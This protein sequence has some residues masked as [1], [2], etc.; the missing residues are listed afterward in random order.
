MLPA[1]FEPAGLRAT[2]RDLL[3]AAPARHSLPQPFYTAAAIH[4][5]DLALIHHRHW[6]FAGLESEVAQP[7]DIQAVEIGASSVLLVRGRDG[8]L[9]AFHNTCRHRGSLL[10]DTGRAHAPSLVCPYHRWTYDLAGRLVRAPNMPPEFDRAAHGLRPVALTI[11]A[12]VVFICLAEDPPDLAAFRAALT[13][14]LAPH[15]LDRAKVVRSI[16]LTERANWKLVW[17]NAREC[18]H[19]ASGH[20]ELMRTLRLFDLSDP[21][22]D[23]DISAFW[24]RCEAS[25][26]PSSTDEGPGWRV[27]RIPLLP[28]QLSITPDGQP[29]VARRLGD[30]PDQDIGSLRW[31][32]WPSV[33]SHVHADYAI[34]VQI[35]PTAARETR[36]VCR[37]VVHAEAE[38]GRDFDPERLTAV[39][40]VTNEQDQRFCE[41]NQRGVDGAGYRP[42]PYSWPGESGV[43]TFIDWYRAELGRAL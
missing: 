35:L 21:W 12:G 18:D 23:P 32:L 1:A 42:G 29:A 2:V 43:A 17:E 28:G 10:C 33:F 31:T 19:C 39:W 36:V 22:G 15:R 20:P 38:P 37:W 27:G 41:R 24:R 5:L 26:L 40:R 16:T 3:D 30:W 9:R 34:L 8:V 4:D 11:I 7:G 6:L 14:R 13:P 25:G